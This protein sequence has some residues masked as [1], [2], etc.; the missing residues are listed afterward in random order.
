MIICIQVRRRKLR[1][2]GGLTLR[3]FNGYARTSHEEY[4]IKESREIHGGQG[5]R[6]KEHGGVFTA[7][8]R[9]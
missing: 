6:L 4:F 9:P 1:S 8:R 5:M 7:S 2:H 3:D